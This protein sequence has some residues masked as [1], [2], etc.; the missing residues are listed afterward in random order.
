M[1]VVWVCMCDGVMC[2]VWFVKYTEELC[3]WHVRG[4]RM[5][6]ITKKLLLCRVKILNVQDN[7]DKYEKHTTESAE[8]LEER[9]TS[10]NC[11]ASPSPILS[12][13]LS[14][15]FIPKYAELFISL[16]LRLDLQ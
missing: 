15:S 4:V 8:H 11:I 14:T 1:C 7:P 5:S 16:Y 13:L 2:A 12:P 3:V 10:A 6:M 9:R